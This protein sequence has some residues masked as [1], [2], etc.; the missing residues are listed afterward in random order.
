V[1]RTSGRQVP[2]QRHGG[3]H[4][5]DTRGVLYVHSCARALCP[6]IEWA[7]AS[8]LGE[9]AD[10]DWARQR[11]EPGSW[12]A[13]FAWSGPAGTA[14]GLASALRAFTQVRLEVTED[15]TPMR[16]GGLGSPAIAA[17][18]GER[19]SYTPTLGIF[20]AEMGAYGEI[21]ISESR[22]RAARSAAASGVV[23]L[24]DAVARL[25]GEPWDVELEPFRAAAD[26]SGELHEVI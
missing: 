22:L 6:H 4:R 12:R 19:I 20:R 5:A 9:P 17:H 8:V 18:P 11:A 15:P 21:L 14:S 25:W 10:L 16:A 3:N 2:R 23:D 13:E 24:A 26:D 1:D 7:V